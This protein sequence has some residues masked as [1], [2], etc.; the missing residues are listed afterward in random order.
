MGQPFPIKRRIDPFPCKPYAHEAGQVAP[1]N[2][3]CQQICR[4][5]GET[6][7][8]NMT[9][10]TTWAIIMANRSPGATMERTGCPNLHSKSLLFSWMKTVL[11]EGGYKAILLTIVIFYSQIS[12]IKYTFKVIFI[13]WV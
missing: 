13:I 6:W 7:A 4:L 9:S 8:N 5:T 2:P 1:G 10:V 3:P 12:P 11:E